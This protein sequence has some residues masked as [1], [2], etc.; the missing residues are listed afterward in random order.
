MRVSIRTNVA[1]VDECRRTFE[2]LVAAFAEIETRLV[3]LE[4][5]NVRAVTADTDATIDDRVILCDTSGGAITV[6]LPPAADVPGKI[7]HVKLI[8]GASNVTIDPDASELIDGSGTHTLT[9]GT[10][11]S[12]MIVSTGATWYVI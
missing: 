1:S 12:A 11:D 3:L 4:A 2:S 7:L 6:N 9:G 5:V 10:L 8:T